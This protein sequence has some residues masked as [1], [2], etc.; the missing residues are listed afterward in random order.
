[1]KIIRGQG[2]IVAVSGYFDPIH[3]G[4]IEYLKL[5]KKL[6]NKLIVILNNQE[7]C[8]IKKGKPFMPLN[9]KIDILEA[10]ECVDYVFVSVDMDRTVIKSLEFIK[11]DIFA[12]GGD[13][14]HDEIPEADICKKL[15]IEIIDD[16]GSKIQ[17]SS[18]LIAEA[19]QN[20]V[21][22][23][24][25]YYSILKKGKIY[26]VKLLEINPGMSLSLQ[27][28]IHRS[29][30]WVVIEG[31]AKIIN[32]DKQTLLYA[33]QSTYIPKNTIH[34]LSNPGKIP[35]KIIEVQCGEYVEEDDIERFEDNNTSVADA[36]RIK[37]SLSKNEFDKMFDKD[38]EKIA[39]NVNDKIKE[40]P[41][42][43]LKRSIKEG[44]K[45]IKECWIP[46]DEDI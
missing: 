25:G 8:V 9:D 24:W 10:L 5:A 6:G 13:R 33:N 17:S 18:D 36:Y 45:I 7:Q 2:Q 20:K 15:N 31:A 28:H 14:F 38:L 11:P 12:K 44:V 27:K 46:N 43:P 39:E 30:H 34:K 4:H 32:G 16:V 22:R 41:K 1:M 26:K 40:I 37:N 23:C 3:S 29:E 21:S 19:V 42:P 35:L